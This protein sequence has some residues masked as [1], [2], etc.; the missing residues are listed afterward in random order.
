MKSC[1]TVTPWGIADFSE[2]L[3]RGVVSYVTP[4]HGGLRVAP[5]W[6]AKHLTPMARALGDKY[7]GA[8][9]YEEDCAC[10]LVFFEFPELSNGDAENTKR[11]ARKVIQTYFPEYFNPEFQ[12]LTSVPTPNY[13]IPGDSFRLDSLEGVLYTVYVKQNTKYII[14]GNGSTMKISQNQLF[15]RLAMVKSK[16]G[17]I[18]TDPMLT[19]SLKEVKNA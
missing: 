3:T 7:A 17:S 6:A 13:L 9:W 15:N 11:T 19:W 14:Y 18:W 2:Q 5:G 4:G 16:T 1:K 12:E 8:Y 10:A